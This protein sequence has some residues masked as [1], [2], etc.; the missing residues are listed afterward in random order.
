MALESGGRPCATATTRPN[1]SASRASRSRLPRS[2]R[3]V[4]A[5]NLHV[6]AVVRSVKI[7]FDVGTEDQRAFL[8]RSALDRL[9]PNCRNWHADDAAPS[10]DQHHDNQP[11]TV[12]RQTP[13]HLAGA[14][15]KAVNGGLRH[16]LTLLAQDTPAAGQR[17]F[18]ADTSKAM[19]RLLRLVVKAALAECR[20]PRLF[21]RWENGTAENPVLAAIAA[22][23]CCRLCRR[24]PERAEI[25]DPGHGRRAQRQRT[26]DGY[27]TGGWSPRPR[28]S[29]S[30]PAWHRSTE[31]F[32]LTKTRRKFAGRK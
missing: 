16:A 4:G 11:A 10:A 1:R 24:V 21:G 18:S 26:P 15:S 7:A 27:A 3:Y 5:G 17:V 19:R 14:V 6:F 2:K 29:A 12:G 32:Q 20:R 9:A 30:S 13:L 25:R 8:A 28:S 23:R 22:R 31:F